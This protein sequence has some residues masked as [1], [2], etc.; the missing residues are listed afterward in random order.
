MSDKQMNLMQGEISGD[1]LGRV[2]SWARQLGPVLE[3][4][5]IDCLTLL[6]VRFGATFLVKN[7]CR[8]S[9]SFCVSRYGVERYLTRVLQRE[10]IVNNTCQIAW[11][12]QGSHLRATRLT[13]SPSVFT[14]R[15]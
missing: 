11:W 4:I 13:R 5:E 3:G 2:G 6:F 1:V 10:K 15:E 14:N 9:I 12:W 8:V 7:P